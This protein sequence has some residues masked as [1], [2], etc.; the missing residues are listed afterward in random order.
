[1]TN[2]IFSSLRRKIFTSYYRPLI[3]WVNKLRRMVF[4]NGKRW[5]TSNP[6]LYSSMKEILR[7]ARDDLEVL[8]DG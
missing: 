5:K 6:K 1:M 4:P 7:E 2:R 8:A 3:L